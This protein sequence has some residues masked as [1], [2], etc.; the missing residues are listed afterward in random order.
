LY[1]LHQAV[2]KTFWPATQPS[3][4]VA[5]YT[6][7][8]FMPL[9]V[10]M[11]APS[12]R[13]RAASIILA[14]LGGALLYFGWFHGAQAPGDAS[15]LLDTADGPL[16]ALVLGVLWLML[17]PFIQLRLAEGSWRPRYAALFAT[18][19]RN[20]IAIAE[21]VAFTGLFWLLLL[22]WQ[23]LF[24]MLGITFFK[25][26]FRQPIFIYPVTALV[27]G[28]A[29]HLIGSVERLTRVVLEQ[30]LS[31]L[32]W[33]ALLAGL[34]LALFTLALIFKLPGM[35]G[36]GER[37]I[38]A[39]WLLWLTAVTVLLV[40][41]AFRDGAV[42]NPYP[43]AAAFA[44]RCVVPLTVVISLTAVYALYVRIDAYGYTQGR[45]WACVVAGA[46]CVYSFGYAAAAR[47]S[48]PWMAGVARVNVAAAW[49]LIGVLALALTP[50]LSPQRIAANSQFEIALSDPD[51]AR[52]L[53]RSRSTSLH[54][55]RFKSGEYGREKLRE[56]AALEDHPRAAE[57][58][59]AAT[60][61]LALEREHE[62]P[63]VNARELL[64]SIPMQPAGFAP[65]AELQALI[66]TELQREPL[67]Y[68]PQDAV[69]AGVA[70]D[71]N[72]D[73]TLEFA[74]VTTLGAVLYERADA[75]WR[76]VGLMLPP[77]VQADK[78]TSAL[79][80][81]KVHS[82]ASTWRELVIGDVAF[83]L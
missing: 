63:R 77:G 38:S 8:V 56:L 37:A 35:I 45:V 11:I 61:M 46:A 17:L 6:L 65:D 42:D 12:I 13:T 27:F 15:R 83:K 41:A 48:S 31:V 29:L 44:L 43:R 78:I 82:R 72:D 39:A 60:A 32:K 75:G 69:V 23:Q 67:R 57:L 24:D 26:L 4:L 58:R 18:A 3:W 19:W 22:L 68:G 74:L 34:I 71:L 59:K 28:A 50:I 33:L 80:E 81:G 70:I 54:Y 47:T 79:A 14:V 49:L 30:A 9:T 53:D 2:L 76:R 51:A 55:L 40:N 64:A 1:G 20:H 7:A 36:S 16:F 66:D 62:R 10:Q 52:P 73:E 5:L 25:E 21:A